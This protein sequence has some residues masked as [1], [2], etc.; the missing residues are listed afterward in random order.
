MI[1]AAI[2]AEWQA[3]KRKAL[4]DGPAGQLAPIKEDLLHFVFEK[5]KQGINGRTMGLT[6]CCST[7]RRRRRRRAGMTRTVR[8][9][10]MATEGRGGIRWGGL[11]ILY[12]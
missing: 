9:R 11:H 5:R 6:T 8:T 1:H 3:K 7:A 12:Y 2:R 10:A 4:L